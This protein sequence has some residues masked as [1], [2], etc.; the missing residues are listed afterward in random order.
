MEDL[1]LKKVQEQ[2]LTAA[3]VNGL[4]RSVDMDSIEV[5]TDEI[6]IVTGI[7]NP[8]TVKILAESF[9][10]SPILVG[11]ALSS[12]LRKKI[13]QEIERKSNQ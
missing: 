8:L 2:A 1:A 6:I 9:G 10:F 11:H 4:C 5:S 13:E 3:Q 12:I 7:Q